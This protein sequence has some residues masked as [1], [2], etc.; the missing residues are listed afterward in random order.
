M[1]IDWLLGLTPTGK[2]SRLNQTQTLLGL[3]FQWFG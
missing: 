1:K 3:V 2:T